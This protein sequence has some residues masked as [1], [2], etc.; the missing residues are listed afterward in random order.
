MASRYCFDRGALLS[1]ELSNLR[2]Q[3]GPGNY[4]IEKDGARGTAKKEVRSFL[5]YPTLIFALVSVPLALLGIP[6]ECRAGV[7]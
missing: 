4:P 7:S 5:S 3:I 6:T 1:S 2:L